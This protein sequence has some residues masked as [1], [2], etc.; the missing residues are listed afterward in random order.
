MVFE[1]FV[2]LFVQVL[3]QFIWTVDRPN[4]VDPSKLNQ[5][6]M[7]ISVPLSSIGSITHGSPVLLD[8]SVVGEVVDIDY[9]TAVIPQERE[10]KYSIT[11][12]VSGE[13]GASLKQGTVALIETPQTKRGLEQSS[14]VEL[15]TPDRN[16]ATLDPENRLLPGYASFQEFWAAR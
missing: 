5:P 7:E 12:R 15:L 4:V 2:L 3:P 1:V 6:S 10:H 13:E 9:G 8:G 14:V 16:S 11:L